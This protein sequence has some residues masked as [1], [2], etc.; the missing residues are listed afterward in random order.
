M[1][2]YRNDGNVSYKVI[3]SA[4][5]AETVIPGASVEVLEASVI[6]DFTQ[7]SAL[8]SNT[9]TIAAAPG[10][11]LAI[12]TTKPNVASSAFYYNIAGKVYY[13]AAVA[14]GTAITGSNVPSGQYGGWR[15]EIGADGT[16][17]VIESADNAT[18][19]ASAALA[20]AAIPALSAD[21]VSMGTLTAS[22]SDG[23]FV[24]GTT[25]LDDANTTEDYVD[26]DMGGL[27]TE[28]IV[29]PGRSLNVSI[30]GTFTATVTL[31]RSFDSGVTWVDYDSWTAAAEEMTTIDPVSLPYRL[32]VKHG[33]YTTGTV[34]CKL[35]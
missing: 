8:P 10:A 20:L 24:P 31:Q 29:N 25:D 9:V 4:N 13:L 26:G 19:Y 16:I 17:D 1:P 14:A 34:V 2:T 23:A 21:H 6:S 7:T 5:V 28:M 22:K 15:F 27:M 32:G 18:G 12:G 3:N 11:G 33:G 30:A 35:K